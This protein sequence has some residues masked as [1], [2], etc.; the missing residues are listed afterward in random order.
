M[1]HFIH[2]I[3]ADLKEFVPYRS[4]RDE[5][6][7]GNIWLNANESPFYQEDQ[8]VSLNRYPEK[9]PSDLL[10]CVA[11]LYNV[12]TNQLLLT[13]GSDE[14]IDLLIRLFCTAAKD[15]VL[16]CPPTFGMYAVCAKLQNAQVIEIPLLKEADF[17]F[18]IDKVIA[19]MQANLK[20]LFLCSPNNPTGNLIDANDIKRLCEAY[21][22]NSM[23]IVDE[24]Y[25]EY[26][27][28]KSL[29]SLINEYENLVVL[30]TF[31]KAYGLAGVRCG[32]LIGQA[33]LV[34]CLRQIIA[35][36]PIPSPVA[37]IVCEKLS[38]TAEQV[39][40]EQLSLIQSEREKL[41][42]A[43][44]NLSCVLTV[45]QSE[46]NFLLV[47]VRN[48][49]AVLTA[50]AKKGVVIRHLTDKALLDNC[51]RISVGLPTENNLI[52]TVLS[53]VLL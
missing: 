34:A 24:A 4:A 17:R 37:K 40:S 28:S 30:R 20:L 8:G 10:A 22:K 15:A 26:A 9:Q 41:A 1:K 47:Q 2:L 38:P 36:Y 25:I 35:P 14:P 33:E 3:R 43:L 52:I 23:V 29:I 46:A 5:N 27:S 13:R 7:I 51:I 50:C 19:A 31:S 18:D 53:Q 48:A 12:Q 39:L 44:R 42:V 11:K 45:W 21:A 16:I 6:K 32:T 49:R